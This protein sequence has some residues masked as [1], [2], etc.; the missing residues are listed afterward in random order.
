[1]VSQSALVGARQAE[2]R[3]QAKSG[4]VRILMIVPAFNEGATVARVVEDL[5]RSM[6]SCEVLVVDDGS[7]D[8]TACAAGKCGAYVVSLPYNCGIGVAM[9]TGYLF[10]AD[11]GYDIAVQVDGDGQHDPEEVTSLIQPILDQTSDMVVGS[12]FLGTNGYKS[13][14]AR[15]LG[16]VWLAGFLSAVT[17]SR[18][19]DPTS[20]FRAASR[21]VVRVFATDYPTDYPEPEVIPLLHRMGFRIVEV[22]V[23]MHHRQAGRSSITVLR[24]VYYM[25]KV[26]LAIMVGLFRAVD[27]K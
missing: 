2:P 16:I 15:R 26:T 20:G 22:P 13:S 18:V 27:R 11:H 19:T 24:S 10:A 12:R 17:R 6:P 25:V 9:Q 3:V 23:T 14:A 5:Y 21:E 7:T 1:M 4:E 8:D